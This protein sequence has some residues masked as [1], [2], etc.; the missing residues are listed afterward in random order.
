MNSVNIMETSIPLNASEDFHVLVP[1]ADSLGAVAV[2]RSLG[3][4]GYKVHAASSSPQALGC[5]SNFAN[6][7][8]QTP[9][10][11]KTVEYIAWLRTTVKHY[12]IVAIIPSE[13]FLLAIKDYFEEFSNL[14][15]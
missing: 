3:S 5:Y 15:S 6:F 4:H 9:A 2:I 1:Q 8:H 13:G 11:N 14:L 7:R 10:Y 12:G